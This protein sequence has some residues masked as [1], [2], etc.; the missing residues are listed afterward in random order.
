[1]DLKS[2]LDRLNPLNWSRTTQLVA[3]GALLGGT[4]FVLLSG[5]C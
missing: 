4:A 3:A 1:M 5:G 2:I